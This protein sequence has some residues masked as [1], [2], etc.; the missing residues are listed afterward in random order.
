[1]WDTL[2]SLYN[3]LLKALLRSKLSIDTMKAQSTEGSISSQELEF[4]DKD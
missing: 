4:Q 3:I 1:M 2:Q